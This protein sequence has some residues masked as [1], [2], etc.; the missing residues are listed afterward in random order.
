M[1][2]PLYGS[3][4]APSEVPG[5]RYDVIHHC[6]GGAT[7]PVRDGPD[8]PHHSSFGWSYESAIGLATGENDAQGDP[9]LA[10]CPRGNDCLGFSVF[11]GSS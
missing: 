11:R 3:N 2:R 4:L 6:P 5:A 10:A 9:D 8:W 1:T 7:Q